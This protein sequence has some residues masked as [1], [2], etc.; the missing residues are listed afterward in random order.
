MHFHLTPV[1]SCCSICTVLI[2]FPWKCLLVYLPDVSVLLHTF[3]VK[4]AHQCDWCHAVINPCESSGHS[5]P[6][7]PS[8]VITP[9]WARTRSFLRLHSDELWFLK[10]SAFILEN[11]IVCEKMI[12]SFSC[13]PFIHRWE[14]R[15]IRGETVLE[16]CSIYVF[17][18]ALHIPPSY[19]GCSAV[20]PSQHTG[21][22]GN[23]LFPAFLD[24]S[25]HFRNSKKFLMLKSSVSWAISQLQCVCHIAGVWAVSSWLT[26]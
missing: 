17:I 13:T 6:I 19:C 11:K 23:W 14:C 15:Q 20:E 21:L 9:D 2:A 1:L 8:V 3:K 7:S 4:L 25:G 18:R 26:R 5:W 16:K 10:W 12:T 24:L 22:G